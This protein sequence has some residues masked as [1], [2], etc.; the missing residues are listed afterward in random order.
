MS[1]FM[2]S[3]SLSRIWLKVLS[4]ICH[5]QSKLTRPVFQLPSDNVPDQLIQ[6]FPIKAYHLCNAVCSKQKKTAD[7]SP[8]IIDIISFIPK[9]TTIKLS[10][11]SPLVYVGEVNFTSKQKQLFL[12][13]CHVTCFKIKEDQNPSVVSPK[14][15]CS[16][17]LATSILLP[18]TNVSTIFW[19]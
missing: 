2:I 17:E 5:I 14:I 6:I 3:V 15:T 7:C 19:N 11:F 18:T 1:L 13:K 12:I 9:I 10:G 4:P 8:L 16:F